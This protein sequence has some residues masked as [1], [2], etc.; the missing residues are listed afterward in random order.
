MEK[1]TYIAPKLEVVKVNVQ[2]HLAAGSDIAFGSDYNGGAHRSRRND[3][4]DD[5]EDW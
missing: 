1:K 4:W 3:S 2:T 5:E